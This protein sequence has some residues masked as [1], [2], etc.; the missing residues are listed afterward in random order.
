[1]MDKS[2][3]RAGRDRL[4]RRFRIA[5]LLVAPLLFGGC[6]LPDWADPFGSDY[7]PVPQPVTRAGAAQA[8]PPAPDAGL[9]ADTANVRHSESRQVAAVTRDS[10]AEAAEIRAAA[11]ARPEI[12]VTRVETPVAETP[13]VRPPQVQSPRAESAQPAA[14]AV[15]APASRATRVAVAPAPSNA[16]TSEST[17]R[18]TDDDLIRNSPTPMIAAMTRGKQP[19]SFSRDGSVVA[20]RTNV[21]PSSCVSLGE[22]QTSTYGQTT[23]DDS[24]DTFISSEP[25]MAVASRTDIRPGTASSAALATA[26]TSPV[27][28]APQADDA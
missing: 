13:R 11:A 19:P 18:T 27:A 2:L 16:G 21:Q 17:T 5:T 14:P 3:I 12:A 1:M 24:S 26:A 4:G 15:T 7:G 10:S 20:R 28:A 23:A 25:A 9:A 6:S 8:I 22:P